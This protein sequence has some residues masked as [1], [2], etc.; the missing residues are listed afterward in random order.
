MGK[1]RREQ[2]GGGRRKPRLQLGGGGGNGNGASG[3]GGVSEEEEEEDEFVKAFGLTEVTATATSAAASAAP[4]GVLSPPA[5]G[6]PPPPPPPL[7][8][9]SIPARVFL[10]LAPMIDARLVWVVEPSSQHAALP[11]PLPPAPT[12]AAVDSFSSALSCCGL[13]LCPS[14]S[15]LHGGGRDTLIYRSGYR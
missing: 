3:S 6:S 7:H 8:L 10:A 5:A 12:S 13:P 14:H 1:R 4:Q 15:R 2:D 9:R 11:P